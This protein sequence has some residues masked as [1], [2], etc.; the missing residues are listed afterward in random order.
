[1][2]GE[3]DVAVHS[4]K[5]L[6]T[7]KVEGLVIGAVPPRESPWD[8]VVAG[9][10]QQIARRLDEI[11][12]GARIGTGSLRR[13]AQ[14]RHAR[15]DLTVV[16]IR[17]NVDTR[18]RKVDAGEFDAIVLARAG[19]VR[20]GF[21]D[22]VSF[23]LRP[24]VMLPAVGQGALAMECRSEDTRTQEL[25]AKLDD[26]ETHASVLAERALLADLRGGCLAPIGAWGRVENR[27]LVLAAV[28]LDAEGKKRLDF[29]GQSFETDAVSAEKLGRR[30][31][32]E[33]LSQGAAELIA[34]S[35]RAVEHDE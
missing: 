15:P 25:L 33:L 26:A 13:Q 12:L 24:P 32:E 5:D 6:P 19:L 2:A 8:V 29:D 9:S 20:L 11:K 23:E 16:E 27:M 21:E 3:V 30:V 14:L 22:R 31:S 17:G 35:R 28:V 7:D 10:Q 1:L 18:L 4:M 34:G